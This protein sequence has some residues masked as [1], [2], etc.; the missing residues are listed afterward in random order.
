MLI[1][2]ITTC[3][4][5]L[6]VFIAPWWSVVLCLLICVLFYRSYVEGLLPAVIIDLMYGAVSILGVP[7]SITAITVLF[8]C[9]SLI[10]ETYLREHVRL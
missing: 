9:L 6:G 8:I 1:R 7:A 5:V 2:C 3:V 10:A 4:I